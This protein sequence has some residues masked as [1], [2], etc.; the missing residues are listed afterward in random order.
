VVTTRV[1]GV[2]LS[3]VVVLPGSGVAD[4]GAEH[5]V[6]VRMVARTR[7]VRAGIGTDRE[8]IRG[9]SSRATWK[10]RRVGRGSKV[11]LSLDSIVT[12]PEV[13]RLGDQ[14]DTG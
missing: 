10:R 3:V 5:P 7:A 13:T 9:T 12:D 11:S 2:A 14:Y 8:R 6:I 1:V 4:E